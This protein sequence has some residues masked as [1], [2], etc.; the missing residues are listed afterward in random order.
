MGEAALGDQG[1]QGLGDFGRGFGLEDDDHDRVSTG[2][3]AK[4]DPPKTGLSG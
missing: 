3:E 4:K 2:D 1:E